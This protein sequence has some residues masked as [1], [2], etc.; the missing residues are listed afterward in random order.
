MIIQLF[1]SPSFNLIFFIILIL[2]SDFV[3]FTGFSYYALPKVKE[4]VFINK[5]LEITNRAPYLIRLL[6]PAELV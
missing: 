4:N 3:L 2:L 6:A 1:Y 5:N